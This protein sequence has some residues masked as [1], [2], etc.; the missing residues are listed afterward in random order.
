VVFSRR[1]PKKTRYW[2][3]GTGRR[4]LGD[5]EKRELAGYFREDVERLEEMLGRDLSAWKHQ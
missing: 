4:S 5:E 2:E 3:K 1:L